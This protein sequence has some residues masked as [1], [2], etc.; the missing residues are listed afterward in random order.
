MTFDNAAT[1][2]ARL[3]QALII[4]SSSSAFVTIRVVISQKFHQEVSHG[5]H[6]RSNGSEMF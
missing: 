3:V 2:L 1:R 6:V 4:V 5:T